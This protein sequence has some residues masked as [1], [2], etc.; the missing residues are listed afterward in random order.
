[1]PSIL[2]ISDSELETQRTACVYVLRHN[3]DF[4]HRYLKELKWTISRSN[5]GIREVLTTYYTLNKLPMYYTLNKPPMY[6]TLNKPPIYY[7]LNKIPMFVIYLKQTTYY[8][9]NKQQTQL[10]KG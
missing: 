10:L 3:F 6:F 5:P 8:T 7:T 4:L 1:M 9:L 2:Q